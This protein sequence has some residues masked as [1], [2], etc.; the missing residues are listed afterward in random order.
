MKK[1]ARAPWQR[2][3]LSLIGIGLIGLTWH[4]AIQHLYTLKP[5]AFASFTTLTVNAQYVIGAIVVFMVTGRLVYEWKMDT[6]S[7]VIEQG[8]QISKE[9]TDHTPSPKSLDDP[10]VQ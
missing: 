5:E 9:F 6:A 3:T 8:D 4:L 1:P 7:Q 10:D 2:L